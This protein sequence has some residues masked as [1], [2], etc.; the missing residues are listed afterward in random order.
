MLNEILTNQLGILI[1][2]E[3]LNEA[4]FQGDPS[5]L[6][7]Q[8]SAKGIDP[9][10]MVHILEKMNYSDKNTGANQFATIQNMLAEASLKVSLGE[11]RE[12]FAAY[13][14]ENPNLLPPGEYPGLGMYNSK[15]MV[16]NAYTIDVKK[17]V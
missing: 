8:A 16:E 12:Q 7:S 15:K 17:T 6:I 11:E 2:F 9:E 13:I 10:S 1:G 3:T 5:I 4:I 14:V